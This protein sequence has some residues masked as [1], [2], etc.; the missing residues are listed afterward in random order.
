MFLTVFVVLCT[1]VFGAGV[2]HLTP[3]NWQRSRSGL[4]RCRSRSS[5]TAR[6]TPHPATSSSTWFALVG[7][8]RQIYRQHQKPTILACSRK[9]L[10]LQVVVAFRCKADATSTS[11]TNVYLS[12]SIIL[13]YSF[14]VYIFCFFF[15]FQMECSP[16]VH[17]VFTKWPLRP[18]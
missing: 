2:C 13:A 14:Q 12:T 16:G 11:D 3:K 18:T 7:H 8:R 9:L 10:G 4:R 15:L 6:T 1:A 5:S 17:A